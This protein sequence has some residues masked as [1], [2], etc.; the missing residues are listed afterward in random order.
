M[1]QD[2]P[3]GLHEHYP[4]MLQLDLLGQPEWAIWAAPLSSGC[5]C[6]QCELL[7]KGREGTLTLQDAARL[8]ELLLAGS[9]P[10]PGPVAVPSGGAGDSSPELQREELIDG[11][12]AAEWMERWNGW[13]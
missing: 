13:Q 10:P 7:N 9:Y 2:D 4:V 8:Y 5:G 3:Y 1:R 12:T 11:F 6:E